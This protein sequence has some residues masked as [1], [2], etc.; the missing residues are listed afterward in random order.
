MSFIIDRPKKEFKRLIPEDG[1]PKREPVFPHHGYAY[2]LFNHFR[3]LQKEKYQIIDE[4]PPDTHCAEGYILIRDDR[5]YSVFYGKNNF[6][7]EQG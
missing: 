3:D 7:I 1:Q 4:L 6:K 2:P 5:N